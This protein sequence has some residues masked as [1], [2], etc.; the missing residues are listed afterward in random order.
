[1]WELNQISERT[2]VLFKYLLD[3]LQKDMHAKNRSSFPYLPCP[4]LLLILTIFALPPL[5][6]SCTNISFNSGEILS[7]GIFIGIPLPLPLP[8]DLDAA[9]AVSLDLGL[10]LALS[11]SPQTIAFA[12]SS[13][14]DLLGIWYDSTSCSTCKNRSISHVA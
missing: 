2:P 3:Y 11:P 4:L 8:F 14:R 7:K 1:M 13:L 9:A 10:T 5:T 12:R 6:I